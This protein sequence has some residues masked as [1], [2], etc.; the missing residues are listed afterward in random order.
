MGKLLLFSGTDSGSIQ[1]AAKKAMDALVGPEPDEFS[2]DIIR[3]DTDNGA[4]AVLKRL[5]ESVQTP[6]F[7]GGDKTIHLQS[8][9]SFSDEPAKSIKNPS[10]VAKLL[11]QLTDVIDNDFP[12]DVNLV[13]SGCGVDP[14]KALFKTCG[15]VGAVEVFKKPE[16]SSWKWREEVMQLMRRR[17]QDKGLNLTT[18][19][20]EYLT[21]VIGTNTDRLDM[22]LEKIFCYAGASPTLQQVQVICKGNREAY[23][24]AFTNAL[25]DRNLNKTMEALNQTMTNTKEADGECIRLVRMSAK[26][27]RKLLD[28]RIAMHVLKANSGSA[29]KSAVRNISAATQERLAG[30]SVLSASDWQVG[31]LG[32]QAARFTGEELRNAI[33]QLARIDRTNVSSSLS[34]RLVLETAILQIIGGT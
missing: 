5:L 12:G 29:L 13:L 18:T 23:F 34:N 1:D 9:S 21:D 28:T 19:T 15:K 8:F 2:C 6:S 14:K 24:F 4:E 10:G 30:N 20:L 7:L 32:D 11:R 25:G 22:E 26:H 33:R 3:E 31:N 16:L 17:A 27:F